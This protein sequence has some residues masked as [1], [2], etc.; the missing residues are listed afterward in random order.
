LLGAVLSGLA[1]QGLAQTFA[2][3]EIAPDKREAFTEGA[4]F[5]R[6]RNGAVLPGASTPAAVG[7]TTTPSSSN[8]TSLSGTA[9]L[10][11]ASQ[12][13]IQA[14][15]DARARGQTQAS[16]DGQSCEAILASR[17]AA[18]QRTRVSHDRSDPMFMRS[19]AIN[20]D[21][22]ATVSGISTNTTACTTRT[23]T[24]QYARAEPHSCDRTFTKVFAA[25][26]KMLEVSVSWQCRPPATGPLSGPMSRPSGEQLCNVQ[27][28]SCPP[29][30]DGPLDSASGPRCR[31]RT[32][33]TEFP[34]TMTTS[35]VAAEPSVTE[36]WAGDCAALD[37][38]VPAG[39]LPADGDNTIT[40]PVSETAVVANAACFRSQSINT[41]GAQTRTINGLAVTR[42]A[43]GFANDY[44]CIEP[45]GVNECAEAR[46]S[47]CSVV[48]TETCIDRDAQTGLCLD[49]RTAL[50]C[51]LQGSATGTIADCSGK[52]V[53]TQGVCFDAGHPPDTD[54]ARAVTMSE[55]G[56]QAGRYTN[57][58]F[59]VFAGVASRCSR[60]SFGLNNCCSGQDRFANLSNNALAGGVL[61]G[62][63]LGGGIGAGQGQSSSYTFDGLFTD[64]KGGIAAAVL[65]GAAG[66]LS[67]GNM[68]VPTFLQN[69]APDPWAAS[70]RMLQE[71]GL[72]SC[73]DEDKSTVL[74]RSQ[75][76]CVDLGDYCER[77]R[78]GVCQRR[79]QGYCCFNSILARIL[80]EQGRPQIGKGWGDARN[81]D[82]SGFT[83][84]QMQSLDFA[85]IDFR[86][87]YETIRART[88]TAADLAPAVT[89]RAACIN[90]GDCPNGMRDPD[91]ERDSGTNTQGAPASD[92]RTSGSSP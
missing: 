25:C 86:E 49:W 35:L 53:C 3:P 5:G 46:Y 29:D 22:A 71:M 9:D 81:P 18:N 36:R 79:T 47:T 54:F 17:D 83:V 61:S 16:Y 40:Y 44:V 52:Q 51:P 2:L 90:A 91:P 89:S 60:R 85:R 64:S 34:A 68:G 59:S 69:Y 92:P 10:S 57:G 62:A 87:F 30:S 45:T 39:Y 20:A 55:V 23:V 82:C 66:V 78:F 33:A 76:L 19:A 75:R 1:A 72:E 12:A 4:A 88:V 43:W 6:E 77:R 8:A 7:N 32:D 28:A 27:I 11:S 84:E 74:R 56:R 67:G 73:S 63:M 24:T 41:S 58:Q 42:P 65:P 13:A 15:E 80:N 50:S 48:T 31:R 38:R 21:P 26:T 14:C 70:V 37:A